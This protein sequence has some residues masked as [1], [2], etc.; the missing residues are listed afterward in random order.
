MRVVGSAKLPQDDDLVRTKIDH[1][2]DQE[3][4]FEENATFDDLTLNQIQFGGLK[5]RILG[6]FYMHD[7]HLWLGSDIESFSLA[8][9]LLVYRPNDKALEQIINYIDPIR[10]QAIA[11]DAEELG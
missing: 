2:Q 4:S 7:N 9:L 11:K 8:S 6:T 5:C 10:A 3:G 1:F